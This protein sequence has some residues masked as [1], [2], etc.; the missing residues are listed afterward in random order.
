[1]IIV[2]L[3]VG[4][5]LGVEDFCTLRGEFLFFKVNVGYSAL[6]RHLQTVTDSDSSDAI[7]IKIIKDGSFVL[8]MRTTL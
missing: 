1:M 7:I 3:G 5:Y 6:I 2:V 8:F 4:N